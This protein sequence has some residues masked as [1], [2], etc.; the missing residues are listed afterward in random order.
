MMMKRRKMRYDN[1]L[2]RYEKRE[3]KRVLVEVAALVLGE[4]HQPTQ[5]DCHEGVFFLRTNKFHFDV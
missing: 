1:C 4:K 3:K 2:W 5:E